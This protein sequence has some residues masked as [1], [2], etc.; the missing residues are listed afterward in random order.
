MSQDWIG[1]SVG[2]CQIENVI[3]EGGMS[4]VYLAR[5]ESVGRHVALKV[6]SADLL[7]DPSFLDRFKREVETTARLQHPHIIPIYDYGKDA[8]V[9]YIVMAY[10][11]GGSLADRLVGGPLSL[12]EA[13]YL[14]DQLA[15]ALDFAHIHGVIHR[16]VK[17]ANVLLDADR[18]VVLSDFGIAYVAA[19]SQMPDL[20][21]IVG[22]P[23]YIAPELISMNAQPG[24]PADIY[25]LGV[26]LFEALTGRLPFNHDS[27][28]QMMWAHVNEPAPPAT[29]A[30]GDLPPAVDSIL[31]KA[32]AKSPT[33]RYQTAAE[34]AED[35][36]VVL[37]GQQAAHAEAAPPPAV[38]PGPLDRARRLETAVRRVLDQVVKVTRASGGAGSGIYLPG[39]RVVT[40]LHVVD[41]AGGIYVRFRTG[42]QIEADFVAGAPALDL[43]LLALRTSPG[44]LGSDRLD[45]LVFEFP[46]QDAGA[47]L[48]AIGHPLDLDW[49]VTGGHFN[50]LRQ[51]GDEALRRFGITLNAPLVQVD[52][53]INPGNSGGPLIDDQAR[54]VGLADSVMNPALVNDIGFAIAGRAVFDFW[55]AHR[56]ASDPLVPYNCGHHHPPGETYCERTG[57]PITPREPV[58]MPAPGS[59]RYSCGHRHA[60]GLVHCPLTGKPVLALDDSAR[61]EK[62]A[63]ANWQ[64]VTCTNCGY[65]YPQFRDA[66]PHCG[67]PRLF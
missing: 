66:C 65:D 41:G 63:D 26:L 59:V 27:A 64:I 1:R 60:P 38:V 18:N 9:P 35:L 55:Q 36:A 21:G 58:P 33:E 2:G 44:T 14:L 53:A 61:S 5:Q 42:E 24:P 54:L 22:T 16:D 25:G 13:G 37:A 23:S 45:G 47:P 30:R 62:A 20:E 3:R 12:D 40:C 56:A 17:P 43:A 19:A 46:T 8:G 7:S 57:K 29:E 4:T 39:D 6:L 50:G 32:L 31:H 28:E 49:A 67:K 34:L 11:A 51:P 48:A 52:A 15:A 10:I